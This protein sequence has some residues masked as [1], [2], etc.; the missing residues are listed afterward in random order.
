[1]QAVVFD[2]IDDMIQDNLLDNRGKE[3][4]FRNR[5]VILALI[6]NIGAQQLRQIF[7]EGTTSRKG[8]INNVGDVGY[9]YKPIILK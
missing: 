4:N 2:V 3:L 9:K 8:R 5:M 1:M 7:W 6:L